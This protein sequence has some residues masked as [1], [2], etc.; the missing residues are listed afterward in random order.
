MIEVPEEVDR[1]LWVDRYRPRCIDDLTHHPQLTERLRCI[2]KFTDFPH[3]LV[4]G[5]CGAGKMTRVHALLNEIYGEGVFIMNL[6]TAQVQATKSVKIDVDSLHSKYHV[7]LSLMDLGFR[8]AA[9]C[10][11]YLKEYASTRPPTGH[12]FKVIVLKNADSLSHAAQAALRR[13]ME[14]YV[15]HCRFILVCESASHLIAPLQSRCLCVRVPAPSSDDACVILKLIL[16]E[17]A[18]DEGVRPVSEATMRDVVK[19]ARRDLRVSLI[20]LQML[21]T[22]A[23]LD[24]T[25]VPMYPWEAKIMELCHDLCNKPQHGTRLILK[26]RNTLYTLLSASLS[27]D[28]ILESVTRELAA[29]K[30]DLYT[31][32]YFLAATYEPMMRNG[33][34]PIFALDAFLTRLM[35]TLNQKL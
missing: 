11:N 17:H 35:A 30:P 25:K 22:N 3:L 4:Q 10:Q 7:E 23:K 21:A 1:R 33:Q 15:A 8:D 29:L 12:P 13:L 2:S 26:M 34:K 31:D 14:V 24:V 9:V 18:Q 16:G 20:K 5:P 32:I 27:P 19:Q 6:H 28:T